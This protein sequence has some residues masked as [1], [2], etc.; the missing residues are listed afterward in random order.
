MSTHRFRDRLIAALGQPGVQ[1]G[2]DRPSDITVRADRLYSRVVTGGLVGL[3]DAY[4]DGWWDCPRLDQFFDRTIRAGLTDRLRLTRPVLTDFLRQ[5]LLNL[6]L[7]GA[8][9]RN[10]ERHY[11]LGDDLFRLT[12]DKR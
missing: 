3:G 4:V 5:A 11:N 2:G 10:A 1:V 6:Q 8:A 12:L 7:R 9:R